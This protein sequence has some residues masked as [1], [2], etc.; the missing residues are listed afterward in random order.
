MCIDL[1]HCEIVRRSADR[2]REF[3]Q[4]RRDQ[5]FPSVKP[6]DPCAPF[7]QDSDFRFD[8]NILPFA[9]FFFPPIHSE[10]SPLYNCTDSVGSWIFGMCQGYDFVI[11]PGRRRRLS[12]PSNIA[13]HIISDISCR[14]NREREKNETLPLDCVSTILPCLNI[15]SVASLLLAYW[16]YLYCPT[17]EFHRLYFCIDKSDR[18]SFLLLFICYLFFLPFSRRSSAELCAALIHSFLSSLC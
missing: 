4:S 16:L 14:Y 18:H 3:R 9:T 8:L 13:A 2:G 5:M 17:V 7:V 6:G 11:P 15:S 12:V 10:Q 1:P